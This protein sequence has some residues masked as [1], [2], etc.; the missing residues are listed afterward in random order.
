MTPAGE[1]P[2]AHTLP[3]TL[4]CPWGRPVADFLAP[5]PPK[6]DAARLVAYFSEHGVAPAFRDLVDGLFAAAGGALHAFVHKRNRELPDEA[7]GS[8][9]AL[10][11]RIAFM[12]TYK[13]LLVTEAV[14]ER[15]FLSAE[16]SQAI[17]AG[18]VPVY[19]GGPP[20]LA[21]F[22]LP[23]GYVDGRT[24]SSGAALWKYLAAFGA[25]GDAAEAAYARFFAWKKGAAAAAAADEPPGGGA[26]GTGAGVA[27]DACAPEAVRAVA[28]WPAPAPPGAPPAPDAGLDAAAAGGWR[29]FRRGLD[30]C[31]H[32]AEC[33]ACKLVHEIT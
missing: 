29:C 33:R 28:E 14:D 27:P 11:R 23:G 32:Y 9:F 5:P 30:R 19:V 16:W 10:E 4:L 15:D 21:A 8:P 12:G 18:T 1:T 6:P 31:V 7:G 22:A 26:L 2:L 3:V 20:N 25:G 17:L 24:F 13:F